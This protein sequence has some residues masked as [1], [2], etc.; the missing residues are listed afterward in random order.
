MKTMKISNNYIV[1][2]DYKIGTTNNKKI[3]GNLKGELTFQSQGR[4]ITG[5]E[6]CSLG[7]NFTEKEVN[8]SN[9][10]LHG[11]L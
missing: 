7:Q 5:V 6:W 11:Q 2:L 3:C 1:L 4:K 10:F 8:Q 9:F